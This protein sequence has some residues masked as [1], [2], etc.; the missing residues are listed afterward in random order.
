M[1][2]IS[3]WQ[4]SPSTVTDFTI[5]QVVLMAGDGNLKDGS[6][7]SDEMRQY[8]AEIPSAKI[9]SYVG[10]CL[11]SNFNKSGMV[12]QDLVNELGR[13]LDY[14]VTN[15]R[16]QG[17][18][19]A[20]GYDGIWTS[21]EGHT[22]VVEV[23]TTDAYR[24]SLD[25]IAIYRD[26]LR[27]A[28][29]IYDASSILMVVGRQDTGELEAQVRGSRHAWDIRLIS[30]E[31]LTKLVTLKE[32]ADDPETGLKIRGVLAPLEYTRL[33][34]LVDVV[35]TTA[36]DVEAA[37]PTGEIQTALTSTETEAPSQKEKKG[38]EFTDAVL[39]QEKRTQMVSAISKV[40]GTPLIQK[41][42]AQFWS[43]DH[44]KRIVFTISKRYPRSGYPYW[45]G[46]RWQWD[47]FLREG[48]DS[49]LTL[50]CMDT[51]FAFMLPWSV[52]HSALESLNATEIE[53]DKYWHI[54]LV[55]A[56][57]GAYEILLPKAEDSLSVN[58]YRIS[59]G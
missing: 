27:A 23:K 40:L 45:Y 48:V 15:G 37:G 52:I 9:A 6:L 5:E 30:A 50:G 51:A 53:R 59:L 46:Y 22:L 36:R 4:T 57:A 18:T 55:E 19:N 42:R 3:L 10:H 8:L 2:L 16:Y 7:C 17:T 11:T 44:Y 25:T 34:T 20:I 1:P 31:A 49:Y 35:F 28:G 43:A 56:A 14:K 26:K 29:T 38:W 32:S 39:L 33:D 12:L 54:H 58:E 41:S 47:E 13:R 21:P 24:I